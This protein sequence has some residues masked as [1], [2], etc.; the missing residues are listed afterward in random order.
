MPKVLPLERRHGFVHGASAPTRRRVLAWAALGLAG[1]RTRAAGAEADPSARPLRI[2]VAYPV[3]GVSDA[4]A[5]VLA[6]VLGAQM[7]LHVVVE[8]RPGVGGML[9]MRTLARAAP[10]G[11][12]LCFAAV[13]ALALH[14][15]AEP[16]ALPAVPVAGVMH[17]PVLVVGTPALEVDSFVGML[18]QAR[19][20]PGRLRWATTGE[21]TTGHQVL[22]CVQRLSG[23]AIVHVP[24][25]GGGQQINDAI[26]GEFEV[27]STNVAAPQ[28]Q[29]IQAGRL[30]ALAVGA[31]ARLPLLPAVPTLAE[32]GFAPANR[33]SHF[34]LFAP[35][36]TPAAVV[37]R[38][39]TEVN[40]AL[41]QDRLRQLLLAVNNL[42]AEG[43]AASFAQQIASGHRPPALSLHSTMAHV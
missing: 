26:G 39:N 31:P 18:A 35:A 42:P 4:V 21:G 10:D 38:L 28:L 16:Q 24:Y 17:T 29:A 13:T 27:L 8:N 14:A 1:L 19:A 36:H 34:G 3:G 12:T 41:R 7:K 23:T 37:E 25:K 20:H 43:S 15:K 33:S 40:A 9:A 2:V 22:E 5:R 32:L 11:R 30:K 6:Q